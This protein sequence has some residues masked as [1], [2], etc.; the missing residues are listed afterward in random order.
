MGGSQIET[1]LVVIPVTSELL[2]YNSSVNSYMVIV[3]GKQ[4]FYPLTFHNF[5]KS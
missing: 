1:V 2:E 3:L 4:V 5:E